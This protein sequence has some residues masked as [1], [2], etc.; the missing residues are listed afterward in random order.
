MKKTIE[1]HS[2]DGIITNNKILGIP[3]CSERKKDTLEHIKKYMSVPAGFFNIVSL[4]PENL[5]ISRADPEFKEI[6]ETAQV[7]IVDGV[8]V[9]IAGKI[10]G[11]EVGDRVT[12]VGL[13]EELIDMAGKDSLPVMLIGAKDNLA[14]QLAECYNGKYGQKN[15]FG[16]QGIKNIKSPKK[17]EEEATFSIVARM[18]P[19]LLFVAFG[20]PYQEKWLW[21]NRALLQGIVC[22]GVGGAFDYLAGEVRRPSNAVRAMGLEWLFRLL[23]QPWRWKRQLRLLQFMWLVIRQKFSS[24]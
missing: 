10:L 24:G 21:R 9:V 6:V 12:G 5:I 15:F 2:N 18:K 4:N 22:M 11:V 1:T 17:E 23:Q 19:R 3:V 20:S 8:G 13:M 7:K 16:T 14:F